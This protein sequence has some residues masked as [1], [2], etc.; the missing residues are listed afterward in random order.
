M[1][2][3][4]SNYISAVQFAKLQMSRSKEVYIVRRV[5]KL[6]ELKPVFLVE[7]VK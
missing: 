1:N 7:R 5:N 2:V 4:F 3:K 6:T